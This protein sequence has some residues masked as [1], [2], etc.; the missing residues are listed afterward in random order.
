VWTEQRTECGSYDE[1]PGEEKGSYLAALIKAHRK[2]ILPSSSEMAVDQ[3][4][5]ELSKAEIGP[6]LVICN[7]I[8]NTFGSP[9]AARYIIALVEGKA[10]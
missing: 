1:F 6:Q 2:D 8:E 4:A 5:A 9:E 3:L 10:H 7:V